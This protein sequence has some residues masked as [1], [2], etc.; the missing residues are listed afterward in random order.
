MKHTKN[1]QK[2]THLFGLQQNSVT[3]KGDIISP[4]GEDWYV[5]Q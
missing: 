2:S 1:D 5:D 4:L 3:I